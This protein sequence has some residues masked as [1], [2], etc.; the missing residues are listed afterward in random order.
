MFEHPLLRRLISPG[1]ASLFCLLL[2]G[3]LW[4][5]EIKRILVSG[6]H[7]DEMS[8]TVEK[9]P[10]GSIPGLSLEV[11]SPWG[12]IL[13]L[14]QEGGRWGF[15]DANRMSVASIR[16]R[17]HE[18]DDPEAFR[19]RVG[20]IRSGRLVSVQ[21]ASLSLA[22]AALPGP[23]GH[24]LLTGMSGIP[25]RFPGV[26]NTLNWRGDLSLL[27]RA[28]A[29]PAMLSLFAFMM[30]FQ[31]SR[32]FQLGL[33]RGTG[34]VEGTHQ[35]H[36]PGLDVLRGIAILMVF[37]YHCLY[38]TFGFDQLPWNGWFREMNAP[39]S[40]LILWPATFGWAGVAV[41]FVVSGFCIQ[42]SWLR[43]STKSWREFFTR[44]SYRIVPP[45]W[46]ALGFF[47][48]CFPP[49]RLSFLSNT[50]FYQFLSH[51]TLVHNL[52][53]VTFFG[54]N[55]SFWSIGVEWQLY[56]VFPL[57]LFLVRRF[58]WPVGL[59]LAGIAELGVRLGP[60]FVSS[61]TSA[62]ATSFAFAGPFAYWLSWALGAHLAE[63]FHSGRPLPW[64][65][66]P[67]WVWPLGVVASALFQPLYPLGFLLTALATTVWIA[68]LVARPDPFRRIPDFLIRHLT[69]LGAVSYSF[70][71]IHQPLVNSIPHLLK[72][73]LP[74]TEI[75]SL[76]LY[77]LCFAIYPFILLLS[78]LIYRWVELPAIAA[79]KLR[80]R[81]LREG[82]AP[83]KSTTVVQP[84]T[85]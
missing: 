80:I 46:V 2:F 28:G 36:L 26:A 11:V 37:L 4:H 69:F 53:P 81:R 57:L 41:F 67:L 12:G 43:S 70:Y 54:I 29:A 48:F 51:F 33:F 42:L 34:S 27:A 72:R 61:E 5:G 55:G 83:L 6:D 8:V 58:G 77:G 22:S 7:V 79:G 52:H 71:L 59:W 64:H 32:W 73:I 65:R 38:A 25:S 50:D 44:R 68:H 24:Y 85:S 39:A 49:T 78:A 40:F 62:S 9:V 47:T 19:F 82:K 15:P 35:N 21:D 31:F 16:V 14:E 1:A 74:E 20:R 30:T 84:F 17:I 76:F 13:E 75:P 18:A 63:A 56:L 60:S 66:W 3:S 23:G 10:G 45:Y